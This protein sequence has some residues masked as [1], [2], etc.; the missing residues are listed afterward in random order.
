MDSFQ[1]DLKDNLA[2]RCRECRQAYPEA[3]WV[4]SEEEK[5][6][7]VLYL[8]LHTSYGS[9]WMLIQGSQAIIPI[10]HL[11]QKVYV[12][13]TNSKYLLKGKSKSKNKP[14]YTH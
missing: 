9:A 4:M 6:K 2:P 5:G 14:Y 11:A 12:N 1:R 8:A 13:E 3:G 10:L 7:G